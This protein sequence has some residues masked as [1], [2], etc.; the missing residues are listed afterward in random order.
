M[1][2]VNRLP[3]MGRARVV[4][5]WKGGRGPGPMGTVTRI[6]SVP[7]L[8]ACPESPPY[9]AVIVAVPIGWEPMYA[10]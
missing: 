1:I 3:A 8:G 6:S 10:T 2:P 7:E 9:E 5:K 4:A